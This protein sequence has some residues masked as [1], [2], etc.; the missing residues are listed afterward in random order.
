MAPIKF[1]KNILQGKE[2]QVYNNGDMA[3]SFTY[4][5][6]II[7]G[8]V[9]AT[10]SEK[11]FAVYNLGGGEVVRLMDFINLLEK[12]LNKKA[13]IK[14]LGMQAGDMKETIASTK[15]SEKEINYKAKTNIDD[16]VKK[17]CAWVLANQSWLLKLKPGKQ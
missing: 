3:R 14:F 9:G 17:F 5:D 7:D 11:K 16:G 13:K 10:R 6:D 2:I 12:Y 15:R 4:I 8:V 1:A